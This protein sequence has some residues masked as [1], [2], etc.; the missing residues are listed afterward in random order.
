MTHFVQ[1]LTPNLASDRVNFPGSASPYGLAPAQLRGAYGVGNISL[2]GLAGD[3]G[4]QT[5][6]IVDAYNDPT[7]SA[8]LHGFDEYYGLPDPPSFKK[9]NQDGGTSLPGTDPAGPY[10]STGSGTWEQEE[11]LDVE[12]AHVIAPKAN[13]ILFESNDDTSLFT[14]VAAAPIRR[15]SR[16]FP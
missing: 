16:W 2:G 8:D 9:L 10:S 12:W 15:G 7:I 13:I 1:G 3:G 5:I 14:A 4:G 6:A 11:S